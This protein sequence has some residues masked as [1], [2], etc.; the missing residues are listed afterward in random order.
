MPMTP[1]A[2][3]RY[4]PRRVPGA[5]ADTVR[6]E[7]KAKM[8]QEAAD[9]KMMQGAGKAYDAASMNY[10]KGGYTKAAD[11]CAKRGKTKGKMV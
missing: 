3:K 1:M 5:L 10:A 6:S 9:A 2:A 11:G 4:K 7:D 8:L